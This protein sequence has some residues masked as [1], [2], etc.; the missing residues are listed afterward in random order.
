MLDP[1]KILCS[2]CILSLK[3]HRSGVR[4]VARRDRRVQDV[5]AEEGVREFEEDITRMSRAELREHFGARTTGRINLSL[6]CKNLIWQTLGRLR[7]GER[8]TFRG[9]IRSYWYSHVKPV[10]ARAGG[11]RSGSDPYG[12]M[13]DVFVLFVLDLDAMRYREFGFSDERENDR[14]IG[15]KNGHIIVA[16]EKRGHF[17]FLKELYEEFDV[18]VVALGGHPSLLS[19]EYFAG[20]MEAAGFEL[21]G[22]FPLLTLVDYDPAGWSIVETFIEQLQDLGFGEAVQADLVLPIFMEK[23]QIRLNKYRLS[24]RKSEKTKNEKWIA[25]S[26]GL[27][28][29]AYGLEADAMPPEQLRE[30]FVREVEQYLNLGVEQIRR[31]RLKKELIEVL[32]KK[33]LARLATG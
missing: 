11:L 25:K 26:G 8:E 30:V 12:V 28:G 31:R 3:A 20:E 17:P 1:G 15:A 16:A 23:E 5:L 22:A 7:R 33:I 21:G 10:L 6:L 24:R 14:I 32:Q 27:E 2:D 9:N 13:I 4:P 29:K 19:T 18:T